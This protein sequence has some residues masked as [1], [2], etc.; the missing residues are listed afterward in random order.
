[1]ALA[2]VE[3]LTHAY[4]ADTPTPDQSQ[5]RLNVSFNN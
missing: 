1:M 2:G 4:Q 3:L 5:V